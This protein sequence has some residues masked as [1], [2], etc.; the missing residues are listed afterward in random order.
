MLSSLSRHASLIFRPLH[1]RD[2]M[3]EPSHRVTIIVAILGLVG[4]LGAALISNWDKIFPRVPR[5][6]TTTEP[7]AGT[8][9]QAAPPAAPPTAPP[10][11]AH[12]ADLALRITGVWRDSMYPSNLTEITQDGRDFR[13]RRRGVL[14]NGVGFESVGT[15]TLVGRQ[16]RSQ[17]TATYKTGATS[18]GRCSGAVSMDSRQIELSCSD[19]LLGSFASISIRE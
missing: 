19:T 3:A 4:T 18:S 2:I 1:G 7:A 14:P 5:A 11:L 15:G 16:V 9:V 12:S 6:T 8:S 10:P 17:Y 13:F